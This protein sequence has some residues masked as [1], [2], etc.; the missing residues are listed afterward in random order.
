MNIQ[1]EVSDEDVHHALALLIK[2]EPLPETISS[3][4][5]YRAAVAPH[6]ESIRIAMSLMRTYAE[7]MQPAKLEAMQEAYYNFTNNLCYLENMVQVGVVS[8]ALNKAWS[9]VGPWQQ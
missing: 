7:Q 6:V 2:L 5:A 8:S 4:A 1:V 3:A 9:G